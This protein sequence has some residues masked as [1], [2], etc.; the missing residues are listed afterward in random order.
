MNIYGQRISVWI[1]VLV[2]ATVLIVFVAI[3]QC[4][5]SPKRRT[6]ANSAKSSSLNLLHIRDAISTF[7]EKHGALPFSLDDLDFRDAGVRLAI[8]ADI[9]YRRSLSDSKN[10]I[11]AVSKSPLD[12]SS[13]RARRYLVLRQNGLIDEATAGEVK[14]LLEADSLPTP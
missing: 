3:P 14:E 5:P 1:S 9:I 8:R 12:Q 6:T 13:V 4:S 11:V 7:R 10:D 2:I